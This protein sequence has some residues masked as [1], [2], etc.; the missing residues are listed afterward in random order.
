MHLLQFERDMTLERDELEKRSEERRRGAER[1]DKAF[2][3][4]LERQKFQIYL[5]EQKVPKS[6]KV[7][8]MRENEDIDDYFRIFDDC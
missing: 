1:E 5:A 2:E 7:R 6:L 8:E 4:E 3:L